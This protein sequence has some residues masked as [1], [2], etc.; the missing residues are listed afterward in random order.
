MCRRAQC[1]LISHDAECQL[2]GE[3]AAVPELNQLID[4]KVDPG[5]P[6]NADG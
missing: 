4:H 5:T 2:D 3:L 6:C 1:V